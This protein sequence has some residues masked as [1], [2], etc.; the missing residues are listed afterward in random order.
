MQEEDITFY[1]Y[2]RNQSEVQITLKNIHVI[3][4]TKDLRFVIHG[5]NATH[6]AT[7]VIQLTEAF[8]QAEDL[9][10]ILVDWTQV[11]VQSGDVAMAN[12]DQT[13]I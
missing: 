8:L 7:W 11:A 9:N 6:N 10:V 13:G 3:D 1:L 4:T 5:W 2:T 12:A